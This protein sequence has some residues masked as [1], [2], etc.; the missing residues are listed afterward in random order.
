MKEKKSRRERE[1]EILRKMHEDDADNKEEFTAA[2]DLPPASEA[3]SPV[4]KERLDHVC[5]KCGR[6]VGKVDMCP[7]CGYRGYMP[8][9][10]SRIK[11]TRMILYPVIL[12]I[13]VVVYLIVKGII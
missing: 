4:K 8:M 7:H 13:A 6:E 2:S 10:E 12:V 11:R 5:P 3:P 1:I 9:S